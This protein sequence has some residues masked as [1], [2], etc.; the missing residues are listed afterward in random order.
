MLGCSLVSLMWFLS[1]CYSWEFGNVC[2][3]CTAAFSFFRCRRK[4][5]RLLLL[6]LWHSLP[7]HCQHTEPRSS[8]SHKEAQQGAPR[9]LQALLVFHGRCS[10]LVLHCRCSQSIN[11]QPN[12][13]HGPLMLLLWQSCPPYAVKTGSALVLYVRVTY[14]WHTVQLRLLM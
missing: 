6:L 7:L 2:A 9:A 12:D 14:A 11:E 13:L 1:C 8:T 5:G 10:Q 4:R 3:P